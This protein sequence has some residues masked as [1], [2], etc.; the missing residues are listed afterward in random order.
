MKTFIANSGVQIFSQRVNVN[1]QNIREKMYFHEW[2]DLNT[3]KC[4]LELVH[5]FSNDDVYV[6]KSD[7]WKQGFMPNGIVSASW[8]EISKQTS[9][10][11]YLALFPQD[12]LWIF[13]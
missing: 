9:K 4:K 5:Y 11:K 13:V 8:D 2:V 3:Y 10:V 6:R 7:L 1:L 12:V